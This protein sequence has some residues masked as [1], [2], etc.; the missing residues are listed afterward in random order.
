MIWD[1]KPADIEKFQGFVYI[2]NELNTGMSYIGKKNY[3]RIKKLPPLKG[4]VNKRHFRVESDWKTYC[5]SNKELQANISKDP[6]NYT[7]TIKIVRN[8]SD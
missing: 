1:R 6:E 8:K 5:G 7:K 2:I 4:K 3:W